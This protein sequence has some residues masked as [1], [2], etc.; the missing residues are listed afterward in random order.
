M[1]PKRENILKMLRGSSK[2][3]KDIETRPKIL[4]TRPQ[5]PLRMILRESDRSPKMFVKILNLP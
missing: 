3:L 4:E 5:K 1:K 2:R